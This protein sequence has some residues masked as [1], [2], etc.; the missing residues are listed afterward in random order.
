M[1]SCI[2]KNNK[3]SPPVKK[4]AS[5]KKIAKLSSQKSRFQ[6]RSLEKKRKLTLGKSI[7]FRKIMVESLL[8]PNPF[9]NEEPLTKT[10]NCLFT[11]KP[12]DISEESIIQDFKEL[13][14]Q[15]KDLKIAKNVGN[16]MLIHCLDN[17]N[18]TL[19]IKRKFFSTIDS[20]SEYMLHIQKITK[21]RI[22]GIET[23]EAIHLDKRSNF[24]FIV[25]IV[26]EQKGENL[27]T[28]LETSKKERNY[29]EILE[30]VKKVSIILHA[31]H[32]NKVAFRTLKPT[33]ILISQD[34]D[35]LGVKLVIGG[36]HSSEAE[37]SFVE[38][39]VKHQEDF[40]SLD[41]IF[42]GF[43]LMTLLA[44]NLQM[45]QLYSVRSNQDVVKLLE[46]H[47]EIP[48]ILADFLKKVLDLESHF[49]DANAFQLISELESLIQKGVQNQFKNDYLTEVFKNQ[50]A[51]PG[52]QPFLYFPHKNKIFIYHPQKKLTIILR[53]FLGTRKWKPRTKSLKYCERLKGFFALADAKSGKLAKVP[54]DLGEIIDNLPNK[55]VELRKEIEFFY[56]NKDKYPEMLS[57][58]DA[59]ILVSERV[60]EISD[61]GV[62]KVIANYSHSGE[63]HYSFL[64]SSSETLYILRESPNY[65]K[66]GITFLSIP[67]KSQTPP[68]E[69][70]LEFSLNNL[71][72][73]HDFQSLP[74]F[75]NPVYFCLEIA[76]KVFF[77][78]AA[79]ILLVLDLNS[80]KFYSFS[81][82]FQLLNY[83]FARISKPKS[84]P[85][86][87]EV[88]S[89]PFLLDFSLGC[90]AFDEGILE[91]FCKR[92][93]ELLLCKFVVFP[94]QS[95]LSLISCQDLSL[96]KDFMIVK[97]RELKLDWG[98]LQ[99]GSPDLSM[100]LDL[101]RRIRDYEILSELTHETA[102]F[103]EYKAR[104]GNE[105]FCLRKF[106]VCS[107][108]EFELLLQNFLFILDNSYVLESYE[109]FLIE[110]S[111]TLFA[112]I[113]RE[114]FERTLQEEF[115]KRKAKAKF[116]SAKNLAF[117]M[118]CMF[119]GLA[120]LITKKITHGNLDLS[121]IV[122]TE[123]GF[124]KV[125]GWY[126]ENKANHT[127]DLWDFGLMLLDLSKLEFHYEFNE[128]TLNSAKGFLDINY[129][130][131]TELLGFLLERG[132]KIVEIGEVAKMV[133]KAYFHLMYKDFDFTKYLT[134]KQ[135]LLWINY[136]SNSIISTEISLQ[137]HQVIKVLD[138]QN[139]PYVFSTFNSFAFDSGE[140][141]YITGNKRYFVFVFY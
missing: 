20:C 27:L 133:N 59:L 36:T 118:K 117:L 119:K 75:L 138:P 60:V 4:V 74:C 108:K 25:D 44:D 28:F 61:P 116:Y 9:L 110:E 17:R 67:L 80:N 72:M 56:E 48:R 126:L 107:L 90:F 103:F 32:R 78:N 7:S 50:K 121:N 113:V 73:L 1:G 30:I 29:L 96:G 104:K 71:K 8:K 141:L 99:S 34:S 79:K 38:F 13:Y 55:L 58:K 18:R 102:D 49:L 43:I 5:T 54:F 35:E 2:S 68:L 137:N 135:R 81:S 91:F 45:E 123:K 41:I 111:G 140:K 134:E 100:K 97:P 112:T 120:Y 26:K 52:I 37:D 77:L 125:K 69:S 82:L 64:D 131:L 46:Q 12:S 84:F 15:F 85:H 42:L 92:D 83:E 63:Y 65:F 87:F 23:F 39:Y 95:C 70:R 22:A 76:E 136:G 62:E 16:S 128:T 11:G 86:K 98:L 122:I 139:Q 88:R 89:L 31:L 105:V 101:T 21:F 6:S 53:V 130:G 14:P 129:P 33:T 94:N 109:L 19:L 124:I 106:K 57:T 66:S 114:Y 3:I 24:G 93:S 40:R 47:Q 127:S 132:D 115:L 10:K 51:P